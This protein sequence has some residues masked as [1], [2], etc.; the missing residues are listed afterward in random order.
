ME[1]NF[2]FMW[3]QR[4]LFRRFFWSLTS[5]CFSRAVDGGIDAAVSKS[6]GSTKGRLPT[7]SHP[8]PRP[9]PQAPIYNVKI[10]SI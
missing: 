9:R 8:K 5:F 1:S 3:I 2:T 10:D 6:K 7:G 4:R